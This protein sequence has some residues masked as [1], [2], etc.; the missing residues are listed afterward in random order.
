[1]TALVS[2]STNSLANDSLSSTGRVSDTICLSYDELRIVNSKLIELRYEK[3]INS[4]LRQIISNDSIAINSLT[5]SNDNCVKE[6]VKLKKQR[7][8][9]GGIGIGSLLLLLLVIAL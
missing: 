3:E 4:G 6:N 5:D 2:Y 1:M 8:I 7:N 9:S